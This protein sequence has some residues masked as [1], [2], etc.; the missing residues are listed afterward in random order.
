MNRKK[1]FQNTL[2]KL[3]GMHDGVEWLSSLQS[4]G[5]MPW[6]VVNLQ[7]VM[8]DMALWPL[9]AF[10]TAIGNW[11]GCSRQKITKKSNA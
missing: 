11:D 2:D 1:V 7:D 5:V 10:T 6:F 8:F 9:R 3:D 4:A